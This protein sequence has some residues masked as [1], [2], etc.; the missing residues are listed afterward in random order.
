MYSPRPHSLR[1]LHVVD[2]CELASWY[3]SLPCKLHCLH[4]RF[5]DLVP[6]MAYMPRP[7]FLF[8]RQ[9]V[10]VCALEL[11]YVAP[12]QDE[13][14]RSDVPVPAWLMYCALLHIFFAWHVLFGLRK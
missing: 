1:S 7:H 10:D 6:V 9:L 13:H 8:A 3:L 2:V 11:M 4:V 12:T 5:V 14:T